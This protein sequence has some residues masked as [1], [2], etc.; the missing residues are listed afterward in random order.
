MASIG[1]V[2]MSLDASV[3]D[4]LTVLGIN[5]SEKGVTSSWNGRIGDGRDAWAYVFGFRLA[6]PQ[7]PLLLGG[8]R[9]LRLL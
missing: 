5:A 3:H 6:R 9:L 1:K 4:R 2:G 8:G 7:T